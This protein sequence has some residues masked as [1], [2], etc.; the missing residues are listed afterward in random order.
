MRKWPQVASGEVYIG[1]SEKFPYCKS[2]RASDQAAQ[3]SGGV[4]IPGGVQKTCRC[5]TWGDGLA[6]MGV[7]GGRLDLMILEVFSDLM[8]L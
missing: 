4:L 6:G 8:I 2:G 1:Y 3:G 5:G 7:L